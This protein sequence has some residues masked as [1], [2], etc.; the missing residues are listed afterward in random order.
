MEKFVG[1]QKLWLFVANVLVL[2]Q[3]AGAAAGVIVD[4]ALF[5]LDTIKTRMQSP[6][7]FIAS[8]GF[9]GIYRGLL[10]VAIGSAPGSGLFF[11][12]Y[13]V[14]KEALKKVASN[15]TQ[16]WLMASTLGVS[17]DYQQ[18]YCT[19]RSLVMNLLCASLFHQEAVAC[20]VRVPMENVKQ[21]MQAGIFKT[22]SETVM[23][24]IF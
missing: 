13:D 9:K 12:T 17:I 14:S 4:V 11:V 5:P 16:A 8:G 7:G 2:F 18:L 21:K 1:I 19:D 22:N 10:S 6:A 20:V 3:V 24:G 15:D 23:I